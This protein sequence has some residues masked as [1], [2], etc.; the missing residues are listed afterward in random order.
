MERTDFWGPCCDSVFQLS[1]YLAPDFSLCGIMGSEG[2]DREWDGCMASLTQWTWVCASSGRWWR[3]GKPG[4]LQSVGSQRVWRDWAPEKQQKYIHLLLNTSNSKHSD[5]NHF[6]NNS[7]SALVFK[8][9]YLFI[10]IHWVL[11][12]ACRIFV[13]FCGTFSLQSTGSVTPWGSLVIGP[14]TKPESPALQGGFLS[15][16]LPQKSLLSWFSQLS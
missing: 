5:W 15:S 6:C 1:N 12:A 2:S 3:T 14:G 13:A 10:W 9:I 11:V 4:V 16:G 7:L 8:N